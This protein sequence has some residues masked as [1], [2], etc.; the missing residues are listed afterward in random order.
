M[1]H[2]MVGPARRM[3]GR[4]R[5]PNERP[6][7]VAAP[8]VPTELTDRMQIVMAVLA[9]T[10]TMREG[11]SKL[12]MARNNFQTLVHKT[13]QA[14]VESLQPK[15]TGRKPKPEGQA[16]MEAEL[17]RLRRR[18]QKLESQLQTMDRLLG[19]AGEVI[20]DLRESERAT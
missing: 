4:K 20:T 9:G 19:V 11:A 13:Q 5:K 7:Y 2:A 16:E 14:M 8:Q 10:M 1:P 17:E 6:S 3:M 18:N 15:P 12:G